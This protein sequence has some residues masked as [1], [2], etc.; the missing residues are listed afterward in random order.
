M[1]RKMRRFQQ[2]LSD[3]E[4]V[5]ILENGS[6]GVLAVQGDEGYPYA[7]P[8]SFVYQDSKIYFHGASSGHK[9]DSVR[10]NSKVSFCVVGQDSVCPEKYT[11]HYSSVIVFGQAH[12]VEDQE[13]IRQASRLLA[14][15]Y[16]PDEGESHREQVIEKN[17]PVIGVVRIDIEHMTGK[18]AKG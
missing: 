4:A 17:M 6:H 2:Q 16:A 8:V 7:V 11:T 10:E 18:K 13:E 3:E 5:K 14:V 1:F 15:K 9:L 12:V